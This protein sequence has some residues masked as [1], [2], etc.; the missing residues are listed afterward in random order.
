[1]TQPG[2]EKIKVGPITDQA[3]L[4]SMGFEKEPAEWENG[5]RTEGERGTYEWW[6]AD[7]HF[8]DGTT[9]AAVFHVKPLAEID[10]PLYPEVEI[11]YAS[12]D[13]TNF[14]HVYVF[15]AK[16]F[17]ASKKTC[18]VKIGKNY[19]RGNLKGFEIHVE[20]DD[21]IVYDFKIVRET[22]SFRPGDGCNYYGDTGKFIGWFIPVPQGKVEA[23]ITIKGE[24]RKL[25]GSAYHDHNWGNEALENLVNHW[26]WSRTEIGPY[27]IINSAMCNP[28]EYDLLDWVAASIMAKHGKIVHSN[29]ECQTFFRST[30][31]AQ[32]VT[33]KLVSDVIRFC[34]DENGKGY[35]L[36]LTKER[37]ILDH[38]MIE[39]EKVRAAGRARGI[40]IGYHRMI[41]KAELKIIEGGCVKETLTNDAA[42]WEMMSFRDPE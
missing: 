37:N 20:T 31:H 35:E 11:N 21:D 10:K 34:Y 24:T 42:V 28:K 6:Y 5:M 14:N 15:D 25:R 36:T 22:E 40:D 1:M 2:S 39:D 8:E 27:T 29:P 17:S 41:G 26:Y 4:K 9:A 12:P 13:G 32:P 7:A 19:F 16:E 38:F 33:G 30:P 18:D 3:K 23:T